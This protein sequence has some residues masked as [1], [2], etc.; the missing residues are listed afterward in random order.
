M[1]IQLK[2]YH[3]KFLLLFAGLL[4]LTSCYQVTVEVRSIPENTPSG[5]PI[6]ISGNFNNWDPGDEAYRLQLLNDSVYQVSLPRGFGQIE[7]K[8]TR[9]DWSTVEKD[10]CGYEIYNRSY[11]Y[12]EQDLVQ[13]SILCWSDQDPVNCPQ[14]TFILKEIPENTPEDAQISIAGNHNNWD[15]GDENFV[16]SFDNDLGMH[17]LTIPRTEDHRFFKYKITRGSLFTE[18]VD[19]LGFE[20]SPRVFTFGETDSVFISVENW[21]DLGPSGTDFITYIID[22]VP[23]NTPDGS[24]IYYVGDI[25]SWYPRDKSLILRNIG[26]GMYSIRFPKEKQGRAFKFTRGDWSTVEV[27]HFGDDIENRISYFGQKDTIYLQII[28]WK[29]LYSMSSEH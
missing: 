22:E 14:V 23:K 4:M 10:E 27:D 25:N 13:D 28:N 21:E 18:E 11:Y 5:D 20:I 24:R 8:F 2:L 19:E 3:T 26:T 15:P 29:D 17:V 1:I 9:G 6:Y 7:Y 12:G 16:F